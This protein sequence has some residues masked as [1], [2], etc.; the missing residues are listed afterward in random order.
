MFDDLGPILIDFFCDLALELAR[1]HLPVEHVQHVDVNINSSN[2]WNYENN[3][4]TL[5]PEKNINIRRKQLIVHRQRFEKL[6][7][8]DRLNTT[9]SSDIH[10]LLMVLK[11][12]YTYRSDCPAAVCA[13]RLCLQAGNGLRKP[14]TTPR[15]LQNKHRTITWCEINK[16]QWNN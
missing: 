7:R 11:I 9:N 10:R 3:S 6:R 13:R 1:V 14:G 16:L 5:N 2:H 8:G 12:T 15:Y 4:I